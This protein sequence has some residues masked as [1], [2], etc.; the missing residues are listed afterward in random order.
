[1]QTVLDVDESCM[2]PRGVDPRT[3]LSF[4]DTVLESWHALVIHANVR[5]TDSVFIDDPNDALG[6][7]M[8]ET[9][10]IIGAH[11][12]AQSTTGAGTDEICPDVIV[13]SSPESAESLAATLSAPRT[14]MIVLHSADADWSRILSIAAESEVVVLPVSRH[15]KAAVAHRH[16]VLARAQMIH[17][18]TQQRL[19]SRTVRRM[20]VCE[21]T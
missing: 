9:A 7:A 10:M 13:A 8:L 1:M 20:A 6:A 2:L 16:R 21:G 4:T 12:L 15:P 11:V 14:R 3:A 18:M 17:A 5:K 19:H